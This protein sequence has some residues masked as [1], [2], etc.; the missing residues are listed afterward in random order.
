[1]SPV[2]THS[3][4]RSLFTVY[5]LSLQNAIK[6]LPCLQNA[7]KSLLCL[8]NAFKSYVRTR[9]Y[10]T[11]GKHVI[12]MCLNVIKV[13]IELG[14]YVHVNN[15]ISKAEQTP[16]V[17]VCCCSRL[18]LPQTHADATWVMDVHYASRHCIA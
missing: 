1:M 2:H 10:C 3:Y 13:S 5:K 15:Y 6:G 17:Q 11:T 16:E 12:Q 9:D 4:I 14:N 8:Q 7:F 18:F